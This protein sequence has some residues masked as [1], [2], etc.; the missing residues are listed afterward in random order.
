LGND[1]AILIGHRRVLLAAGG[2]I[3]GAAG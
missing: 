3:L 1:S 2:F